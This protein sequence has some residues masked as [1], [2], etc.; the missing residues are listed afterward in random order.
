MVSESSSIDTCLPKNIVI[1][2]GDG[3][4]FEAVKAAGYYA[5]GEAGTL[6]F[7]QFPYHAEIQTY[8]AN[9]P[10]TDSAAAATAVA[11]GHK[12]NNGVVSMEIPGSGTPLKTLLEICKEAN[13]RTG[14]VTTTYITHATP[15]CFGAHNSQRNNLGEIA[16]DYLHLTRPNVLL[17][18]GGNGISENR[19]ESAGYTVTTNREEL[20]NLDTNTESYV[21][22]QFG[23]SNIPYMFDGP[24]NLPHLTEMVTVALDILTNT[25]DGF[26]LLLEGGRIDHAGHSN[27]I[28]RQLLE[29]IEFAN[30][31][32]TVYARVSDDDDTL[33]LVTAD[34]ETGGL[35]VQKNNGQGEIPKI[36]WSTGGHSVSNV[37][38]Y[39]C[40]KNAEHV[41]GILNNSDIIKIVMGNE[42][43][44]GVQL[45][46]L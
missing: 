35:Q 34:H 14:L 21:S 4:G 33:I 28:E 36:T 45:S 38:L 37:P 1:C 17:G 44:S 7:E 12:V 27:D 20:L 11:T 6:S 32:Q 42:D 15:A 26:F 16:H 3:M 39:G 9:T 5:S 18:G 13:K 30:A 10:M 25:E 2:I 31:V 29:T 19:A 8:A 24:N 46:L 22:G 40:G 23:Q 41:E 43:F